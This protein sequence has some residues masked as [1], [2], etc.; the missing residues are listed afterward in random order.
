MLKT[1]SLERNHNSGAVSASPSSIRSSLNP[2][3]SRR[4]DGRRAKRHLLAR[5]F[6]SWRPSCCSR[7]AG[8]KGPAPTRATTTHCSDRC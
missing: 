5:T 7:D 3:W 2:S 8:R 6:G 4:P 1:E